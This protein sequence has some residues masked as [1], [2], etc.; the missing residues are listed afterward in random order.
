MAFRAQ[1]II[2]P[3]AGGLVANTSD[4][5]G[6]PVA[7]QI[8]VN[9]V[10]SGPVNISDLTV[11]ATGN[12]SSNSTV[13]GI[14]YQNSSGTVNHVATRNQ[15]IGIAVD[16]GSSNPLVTIENSS[17][18]DYD[19]IGISVEGLQNLIPDLTAVIKENEV[20]SVGGG[21]SYGIQADGNVTVA[22]NLFDS[23]FTGIYY[24]GGGAA[25][26]S[27]NTV[28][29]N[30]GTIGIDIFEVSGDH[31]S[32]TSNKS[33]TNNQGIV[34]EIGVGAAAVQGNSITNST[35]GIEFNCNPDPNVHSNII[36]DTFEG[37][38]QF[39]NYLAFPSNKYFNVGVEVVPSGC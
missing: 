8:L 32:V 2:A 28:V 37:I 18:H 15:S 11:D 24:F 6:N 19:F 23:N 36:S 34:L 5:L 29:G 17:V 12:G 3:P 4:V 16:G 30:S 33:V 1:A 20:V 31:I 39:P 13:V 26:I 21:N 35:I 9:Q 38:Q 14:C 27:G 7:A 25:S 10:A 22:N